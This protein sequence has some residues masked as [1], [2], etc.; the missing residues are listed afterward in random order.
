MPLEG[1]RGR[2]A[3]PTHSSVPSVN[4]WCFQTGTVA[5]SSSISAWQAWNASARC[6]QETPTM[7]AMSPTAPHVHSAFPLLNLEDPGY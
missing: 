3:L 1:A 7:T 4:S 5:F 2:Y 6:A